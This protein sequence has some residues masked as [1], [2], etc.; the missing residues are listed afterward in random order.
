MT[1]QTRAD[2]EDAF[3][4]FSAAARACGFHY[5]FTTEPSDVLLTQLLSR[6]G[7]D[8]A[9]TDFLHAHDPG[10]VV[11]EQLGPPGRL[12]MRHARGLAFQ[13][14]AHRVVGLALSEWYFLPEPLGLELEEIGVTIRDGGVTTLHLPDVAI[15]QLAPGWTSP[16]PTDYAWLLEPWIN[17]GLS[18]ALGQAH[19]GAAA[20]AWW[21]GLHR[22]NQAI[23]PVTQGNELLAQLPG[24][25]GTFHGV[26]D[27]ARR[28]CCSWYLTGQPNCDWCMHRNK[29]ASS[30]P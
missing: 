1:I 27:Y 16:P 18:P 17:H 3:A 7:I 19:I 9:V 6:A 13:R 23:E 8:Q 28:S 29:S 21:R 5:K 24:T 4:A 15:P 22:S 11:E 20:A 14:L 2:A 26:E 10:R 12:T 25:H 30:T